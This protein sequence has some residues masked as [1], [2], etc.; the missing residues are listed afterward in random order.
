[1]P[2]PSIKSTFP[3]PLPSYLPRTA[4]VPVVMLH[5]RDPISTDADRFSLSMNGMRKNHRRA[6]GRT[7]TLVCLNC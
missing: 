3:E 2:E 1:M 7:E 5:T 4:K 6:R